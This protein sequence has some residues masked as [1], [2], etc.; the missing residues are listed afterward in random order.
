MADGQLATTNEAQNMTSSPHS[1]DVTALSAQVSEVL[2]VEGGTA[3][4]AEKSPSSTG[5]AVEVSEKTVGSSGEEATAKKEEEQSA[6]VS[7][8]NT[9]QKTP[10]TE[11]TEAPAATI[12]PNTATAQVSIQDSP[13]G[14]T[15][16]VQEGALSI[17]QGNEATA[18]AG[19]AQEAKEDAAAAAEDDKTKPKET[20]NGAEEPKKSKSSKEKKSG[21]C[22]TS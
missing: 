2:K 18:A 15:A 7:A 17:E 11:Q 21:F 13:E 20:V 1:D 9:A 6:D 8:E 14:Q 3:T 5:A 4:D 16:S 12:Q 10:E 19:D 22:K